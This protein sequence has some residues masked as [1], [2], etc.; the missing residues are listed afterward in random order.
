MGLVVDKDG[1][2]WASV[3]ANDD[4][5]KQV[6]EEYMLDGDEKTAFKKAA[7]MAAK[8]QKKAGNET[9]HMTITDVLNG[10]E[11][12]YAGSIK[13]KYAVR[14]KFDA[15]AKQDHNLDAKAW[16]KD[17]LMSHPYN[18]VQL[19]Q[20]AQAS[21]KP[22]SNIAEMN[23]KDS[24]EYSSAA[25]SVAAT[26]PVGPD[27]KPVS[28]A[29]KNQIDARQ[30]EVPQSVSG[31]A[32]TASTKKDDGLVTPVASMKKDDGWVTSVASTK[33]AGQGSRTSPLPNSLAAQAKAAAGQWI[34][35]RNGPYQLRQADIEW[36]KKKVAARQQP[37]QKPQE[38]PVNLA[39]GLQVTGL[40]D[41]QTLRY[42]NGQYFIFDTA[43]NTKTQ[44]TKENA[45]KL[46]SDKKKQANQQEPA[47]KQQGTTNDEHMKNI[48]GA[49]SAVRY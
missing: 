38:T 30:Y 23:Q 16:A 26:T 2:G 14:S 28:D 4:W 7:N 43:D 8:A 48:V 39:G 3:K 29:V 9:G 6:A 44:I 25:T 40:T 15:M 27:G 10:V 42:V 33:T 41:S 12:K 31:V 35:T 37:A 46:M 11:P 24:E 47:S 21:S 36:A 13:Y 5:V 34:M 20:A 18:Q 32:P 19:S 22:T 1:I 45:E 49:I 17:Y